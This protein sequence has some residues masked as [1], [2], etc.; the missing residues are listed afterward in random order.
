M[1]RLL[2]ALLFIAASDVSL[3]AD[4]P[5]FISMA[6]EERRQWILDQANEYRLRSFPLAQPLQ[7]EE[8]VLR[9]NDSVSGVVDAVLFV[10]TL[11]GR[12]EASASF[13]YRKDG[14]KAHEFVSLS[15][16][17]IAAERDD[18]DVWVPETPGVN[19]K[20]MSM[21]P[22][23]LASKSARLT[24][25]R[26]L[27]RRCEATTTGR[28]GALEL[29]LLPQ[30]MMRYEPTDKSITDGAIFS[31]SKGT[32]PEVLLLIE[33]VAEDA[34]ESHYEYAVVRMTSRPCSLTLDGDKV[35]DVPKDAGDAPNGLY[36]NIYGRD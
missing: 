25:M 21:A 27:A 9:F 22:T 15:R 24:Q 29:R 30:P 32:N 18:T 26:Q 5:S 7:R 36:R 10:W 33:A 35:W 28:S 1:R 2:A 19:F 3:L 6:S 16:A 14:L 23:P 12:P 17:R 34:G 4:E 20:P 8:P 11:D 31:F 13:W